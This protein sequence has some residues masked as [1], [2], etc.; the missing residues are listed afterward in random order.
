MVHKSLINPTSGPCA[1]ACMTSNSYLQ[2]KT[3]SIHLTHTV[4]HQYVCADVSSNCYLQRMTHRIHRTTT[5]FH[6][7]MLVDVPYIGQFQWTTCHIHRTRTV[8]YQCVCA[9]MSG[10][11]ATITT[12]PVAYIVHIRF[13]FHFPAVESSVWFY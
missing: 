6:Q 9:L 12:Q 7:C 1:S 3:R 10:Q 2:R 4:F 5:V 11:F 8:Y 13:H